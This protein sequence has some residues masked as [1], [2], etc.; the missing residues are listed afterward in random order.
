MPLKRRHSPCS[1][2]SV[3]S[4]FYC[5]PVCI[6]LGALRDKML[7]DRLLEGTPHDRILAF[8]CKLVEA[9]TAEI[10]KALNLLKT[11]PKFTEAYN[12]F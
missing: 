6:K 10:T 2:R 9:V 1:N 4:R 7:E 8:E 11:Q 12:S 5:E 3:I